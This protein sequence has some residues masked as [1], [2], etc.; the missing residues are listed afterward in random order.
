L[1]TVFSTNHEID[2]IM[3]TFSGD[4]QINMNDFFFAGLVVNQNVIS[5]LTCVGR[6]AMGNLGRTINRKKLQKIK[7]N[8]TVNNRTLS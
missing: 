4:H 1:G 5:Q 2:A 3:Q 6:N 7:N 8:I